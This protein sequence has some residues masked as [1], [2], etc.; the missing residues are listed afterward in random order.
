MQ[1]IVKQIGNDMVVFFIR[2]V[3][4]LLLFSGLWVVLQV[5]IT[6]Q[7]LYEKPDNITRFAIAIQKGSNVDNAFQLLNENSEYSSQQA[8]TKAGNAY[9]KHGSLKLSYFFAWVVVMLL[10][11][12]I[13]RISLACVRT[14]SELILFDIQIK[15]LMRTLKDAK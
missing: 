15:R 3:G 9:T 14:G 6:A 13:T 4:F 2:T 8:N 5:L 7:D 1:K 10:F 12:L 11:L